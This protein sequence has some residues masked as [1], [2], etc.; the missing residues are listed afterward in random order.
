MSCFAVSEIILYSNNPDCQPEAVFFFGKTAGL[1][2]KSVMS[3]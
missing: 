3:T 1:M 2:Q